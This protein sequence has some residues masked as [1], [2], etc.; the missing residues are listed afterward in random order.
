MLATSFQNNPF[1]TIAD[2]DVFYAYQARRRNE[3]YEYIEDDQGA[4]S[5][6]SLFTFTMKHRVRRGWRE[7]AEA[8]GGGKIINGRQLAR[9]TYW[10]ANYVSAPAQQSP[11]G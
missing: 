9:L 7:S 6:P 1:A 11:L 5:S 4:T 2:S 10:G 8:R 3:E